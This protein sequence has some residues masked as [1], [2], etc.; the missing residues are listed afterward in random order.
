MEY[1]PNTE[2]DCRAMLDAIG[3]RSSEELFADIPQ[4][5]KLKRGL[6]LAPPLSETGLRKHMKELAGKNADVDQYASFLGAGAYNHFIPAAVSHLVFRS[7]FYTAYTPYQPELSQ[8]TLQAIYE[9]QTLICQLTGMEVANASMYD[10][11]SSLAEAVL[12][13]HRINGRREVVL[14]MAVHPE[15]R[16]VCRT[17]VSK[18][19]LHLHEVPYTDQGATDLKQVKATLSDRTC[20]VVVQSPNFFGVLESLDELAEVAHS[21]GAL[22]IVVVAEPV[23]FGIVRS[24]GEYGADIVVGEGQAFGNHLNFGGPYLGFFASKQAYVRS[25]PGRLVGRTEDKVG[26]SGY[27]LTLSTREQH[28]RREKATSNICTNEGLCALAATV[29]LSLLGR[30]GLR[31]LALLNLRKTAYTKDAISKLSGYELPFAGP[32]FNEFV[33]RVKKRTPAQVNRALLAKGIIGGVELGR[34]YP[35]LSDCLLLCVTEQ[36]SREEIDALCKAMGGGR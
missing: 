33:V 7:E 9:Y 10:G 21:A 3:V 17:Y 6:N 31:E 28:I 1:I 29:H 16:T 27:V 30:A 36:N 34:F 15:Y 5:L 26:R 32:T 24:P 35:E 18:L 19:G 11:S 23:S 12:M 22:L 2:A 4:K 8:G 20:A 25:M 13:A 14:P